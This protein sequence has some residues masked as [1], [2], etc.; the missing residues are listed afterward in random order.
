MEHAVD[1]GELVGDV[2]ERYGLSERA[3]AKHVQLHPRAAAARRAA[4]PAA[5][6]RAP[7]PA[8]GAPAPKAKTPRRAAPPPAAR[9][10]RPPPAPA[11]DVRRRTT[12]PPPA[13][14]QRAEDD[15]PAT[16]RSPTS[17]T[18]E[19]TSARAKVLEQI[20]KLEDLERSLGKADVDERIAIARALAT[21]AKTLGH[22]TGELGA[23][24]ATVAAS[25]HYR[26]VR[27]AI[28]DAL[29]PYPDALRAVIDALSRLEPG[30]AAEAAA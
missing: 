2:A 16:S 6:R 11:R 10:T 30:N 22:L 15:G 8:K 18:T 28:V 24:D 7:S 17:T 25:P 21:L 26:R 12:P 13:A 14:V 9:A 20:R 27:T 3:V 29:K 23:S 4:P 5:G 1:G 19:T